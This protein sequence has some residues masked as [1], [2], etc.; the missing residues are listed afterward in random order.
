ME[1]SATGMLRLQRIQESL[2]G[3]TTTVV[4]SGLTLSHFT[5]LFD[6][7]ML[8]IAFGVGVQ[9]FCFFMGKFTGP[10]RS[11]QRTVQW[12]FLFASV[13][14]GAT[15]AYTLLKLVYY[16]TL[17]EDPGCAANRVSSYPCLARIKGSFFAEDLA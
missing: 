3:D 14:G 7:S 13:A 12:H 6:V 10:R 5:T 17:F 4:S 8:S 11:A 16:F 15:A 1:V 9:T 2:D